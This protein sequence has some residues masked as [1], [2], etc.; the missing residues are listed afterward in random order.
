MLYLDRIE[1]LFAMSGVAIGSAFNVVLFKHLV[2][3]ILNSNFAVIPR[4]QFCFFDSGNG[5]KIFQ[6]VSDFGAS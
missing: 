2:A 5:H 4:I 3:S 1:S 6:A